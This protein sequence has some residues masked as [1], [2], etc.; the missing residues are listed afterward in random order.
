MK[1]LI[2]ALSLTLASTA[3]FANG[4]SPWE[5][6]DALPSAADDNTRQISRVTT[7]FAP[8]RDQGEREVFAEEKGI[9]MDIVE[10]NIFRPWS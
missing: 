6:R 10:R 9:A 5:N 1:N 7:G 4:F 8:W 3:S 2:I